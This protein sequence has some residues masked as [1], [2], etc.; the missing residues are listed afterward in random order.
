[1]EHLIRT[2]FYKTPE[3]ITVYLYGS[4]ANG[5]QQFDSDV[6]IGVLFRQRDLNRADELREQFLLKLSRILKKD[7]HLVI[8]N[9]A[10]EELLR[11]IFSKGRC[12]H[13]NDSKLLSKFTM[14]ALCRIAEFGYYRTMIQKGF[15]KR[16]G[17]GYSWLIAI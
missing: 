13:V 2:Y 7:L 17:G 4:H 6:D 5:R 12:V 11:Q 8:M 3:V 10:A 9:T 15:L 14:V 1:M 16:F